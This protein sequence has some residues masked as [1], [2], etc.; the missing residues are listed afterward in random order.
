[1]LDSLPPEG[2]AEIE[3]SH[4]RALHLSLRW[5][6]AFVSLTMLG[7]AAVD[8]LLSPPGESRA[9]ISLTMGCLALLVYLL[10]VAGGSRWEVPLLVTGV[11]A[12]STWGVAS[13]GSVRAA[14][15]F[16][17]VGAVVMAGT[18]L[19]L[20]AVWVTMAAGMLLL[21]AL[22]WAESHGHL[23]P[24][25]LVPDMRYWLMGSAI[26]V[27]IGAQLYHT[28]K[29][30]D[31]VYLRHL[32][33]LEERLRLEHERDQSMRRFRRIFLLNPTA[34]LVQTANTQAVVEVN[35]AFERSF[36]YRA[37]QI[38]GQ[39]ADVF[40]VDQQAWQ[41]HRHVLIERGATGWQRSGWRRADGSLVEVLVSS[42]LSEDPSGM[43]ILT[44]V[45]DAAEGA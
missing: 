31:E 34:L 35:P 29:S 20:R 19:R 32:G 13:F 36:G 37:D 9:H 17:Y 24:A 28:R 10:V 4:R 26:M 18:Y 14:T 2:P 27:L 3:R 45:I 12:A 11:L 30:T 8:L 21:A 23:P 25:V 41:E 42:E 44:T 33:Q 5:V 40:W 39:R 43:L 1:M 6:L 38:A 16:A 22:T 15:T 7:M